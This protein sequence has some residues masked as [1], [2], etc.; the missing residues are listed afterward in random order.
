MM[1]P[2]GSVPFL[3]SVSSHVQPGEVV[4]VQSPTGYQEGIVLHSR[5]DYAVRIPFSYP[6]RLSLM[7]TS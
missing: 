2:R 6:T 4:S 1:L 3:C 7:C 5:Y